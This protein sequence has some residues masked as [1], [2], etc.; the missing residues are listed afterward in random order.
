MKEYH[1]LTMKDKWF[2][3]KFDPQKLQDALNA[4]AQQGWVLKCCATADVPG[5]GSARQEFVAVL[6]RDA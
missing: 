4:Y 2:S 3:G 5:F 1:V 6:E